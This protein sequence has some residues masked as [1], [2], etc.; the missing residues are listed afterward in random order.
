M[1][2]YTVMNVSSRGT[3]FRNNLDRESGGS[4]SADFF[5]LDKHVSAF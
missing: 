2:A 1:N 5:P 3:W 4:S